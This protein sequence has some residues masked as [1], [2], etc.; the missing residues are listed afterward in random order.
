[1]GTCEGLE[2]TRI[3]ANAIRTAA[4]PNMTFLF[5]SAEV[6]VALAAPVV[7]VW[8]TTNRQERVNCKLESDK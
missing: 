3:T 7:K 4:I 5:I 1:M 2:H 8:Q 6:N